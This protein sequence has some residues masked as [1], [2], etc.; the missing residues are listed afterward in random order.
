MA[1]TLRQREIT[2]RVALWVTVLA[3]ATF[4]DT[5]VDVVS[6]LL[7]MVI[8]SLA[9]GTILQVYRIGPVGT[10][11]MCP[12]TPT[13]TYFAPSLLAV[14]FGGLPMLFGMTIFAGLLEGVEKR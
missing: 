9:I 6:S 5:P 7:A 13:A 10:G 11:F 8:W 12:A 1:M 4:A 14:R 3:F 2:G